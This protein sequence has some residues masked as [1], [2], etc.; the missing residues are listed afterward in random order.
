MIDLVEVT[1][2]SGAGGNGA[3]S[4]RREKFVP[5]GGPGG[6][7]GGRG[8]D[9]IFRASGGMT[10]LANFRHK[11]IYRAESGQGGAGGKRHGR[12]GQDLVIE[13]PVGTVINV[14]GG[15][16][17]WDFDQA[18]QEAVVAGGGGGGRGNARFANSIRQAPGFAEKGMPGKELSLKL[19]LK[20]LADVGVVGLPNA[21]KSTLLR[22]VSHAVPEVGDFP[23]TT[24]EPVPG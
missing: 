21:G 3:V 1:V 13:V 24:L 18:E 20:L 10:T 12:N 2:I 8:G 14:T 9:V 15:E 19:E 4:F 5:R 11:R 17:M 6:G 7:D 22:A 16:E 23:F